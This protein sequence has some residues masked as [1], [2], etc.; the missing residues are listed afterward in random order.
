MVNSNDI[1]RMSRIISTD[2]AVSSPTNSRG[3]L[4]DSFQVVSFQI[5]QVGS[6]QGGLKFLAELHNDLS[7]GR[8][9]NCTSSM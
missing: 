6:D 4:A 2:M 3:L 9:I 8:L 7:M 5:A 1:L